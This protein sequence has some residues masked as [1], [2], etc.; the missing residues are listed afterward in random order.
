[1]GSCIQARIFPI[2]TKF[3]AETRKPQARYKYDYDHRVRKTPTFTMNATFCSKRHHSTPHRILPPTPL[4]RESMTNSNHEKRDRFKNLASNQILSPLMTTEF[5]TQSL[6]IT[7]H[8]PTT[9]TRSAANENTTT[10]ET[11]KPNFKCFEDDTEYTVNR[12]V[13]YKNKGKDVK[14]FVRW[15]RYGP[16]VKIVKPPANILHHFITSYW[17]KRSENQ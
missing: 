16:V 17:R 6:W 8:T 9:R 1:M 10:T 2:R 15:Y 11:N 4:Q 14:Y 7:S 5:R 13:R 12:I 3:D